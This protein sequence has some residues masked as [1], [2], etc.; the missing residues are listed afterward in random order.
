[1]GYEF[2]RGSAV[3]VTMEKDSFVRFTKDHT[4]RVQR[5]NRDPKMV[6]AIKAG[7]KMTLEAKSRLGTAT[8]STYSLG[9][10]KEALQQSANCH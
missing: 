4:A 6:F 9:G 10:L 8:S 2:R 7:S 5:E 1:M 3:T